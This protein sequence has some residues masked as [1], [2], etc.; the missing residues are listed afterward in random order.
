MEKNFLRLFSIIAFFLLAVS[1]S[2]E[3]GGPGSSES[4][5]MQLGENTIL[6]NEQQL[7]AV[8][9]VDN[10]VLVL[11]NTIKGDDLPQVGQ[12]L[13]TS[14]VNENMPSGF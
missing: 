13:L 9:S 7:D 3:D 12:I 1:C 5:E 14:E 6:L 2:E 10:D 4:T 11:N 8:V